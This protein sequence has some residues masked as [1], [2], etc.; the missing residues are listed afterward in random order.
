MDF[1]FQLPIISNGKTSVL[2]IVEYLSERVR[3]MPTRN[4]VTAEEVAKLLPVFDFNCEPF[5]TTPLY[6][7]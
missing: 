5:W 6:C 3:V 4:N 2:M 7:Q 1:I